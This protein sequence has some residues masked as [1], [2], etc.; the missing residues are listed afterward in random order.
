VGAGPYLAVGVAG[1]GKY[2]MTET[3]NSETTTTKVDRNIVFGNKEGSD[4]KK[5][6]FG[7]NFLLGYQWESGFNVH[8]NYGLGLS[9]INSDRELDVK[10]TNVALAGGLG[11][12]F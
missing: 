10:T 5:G 9:D 12:T 2:E 8:V 1:K 7:A 4:M 3:I 11:F 6:D